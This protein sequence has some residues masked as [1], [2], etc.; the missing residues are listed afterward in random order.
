MLRCCFS[1]LFLLV[2]LA[3]SFLHAEIIDRVV[4]EVN[5][6]V[7]TLSELNE[8]SREMLPLIMAQVPADEQEKAME[9]AR[10]EVLSRMIDRRI[11][12]QMAEKMDISVTESEIDA[13]IQ[14]VIEQNHTT[15]EDFKKEIAALGIKEAAYRET[16]REQVLYSK[17]I[18]YEVNSKIVIT[19]E[20]AKEYYNDR[21]MQNVTP[22]GY[23]LLQIGFTWTD[24]NTKKEA[25]VKAGKTRTMV[26]NGQNFTEV[27]RAVSELPS[28]ADNGDLGVIKEKEMAPEMRETV[29]AMQP[30][31]ISPVVETSSTY[32]FF[33]LLAVNKDGTLN[34]AP[35]ASVLE[36]I[37]QTLRKEEQEKLY[38]KWVQK[39][40]EEAYIKE[41]L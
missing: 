28:A 27:A 24:D 23:Y 2:V 21:F 32:Q 41:M 36:D 15:E 11:T 5:D 10:R 16:I 39:L 4:A 30:G 13:A 31:D 17:L 34:R 29:T 6:D 12:I 38:D 1:L 37:R 8:E 33:K 18:G 26:L 40:R 25:L 14:S 7:I 20:K 9:K 19:D 22:G 35:F 3:P